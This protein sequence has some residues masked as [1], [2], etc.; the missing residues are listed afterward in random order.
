MLKILAHFWRREE[1]LFAVWTKRKLQPHLQGMKVGNVWRVI[2]KNS[3]VLVE[4]KYV[5]KQVMKSALQ[6]ASNR[7]F[8][9]KRRKHGVWCT[10]S[11][12]SRKD[13]SS[14]KLSK[15]KDQRGSRLRFQNFYYFPMH[16]H[17]PVCFL[18]TTI[19]ETFTGM[20]NFELFWVFGFFSERS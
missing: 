4:H 11:S 18:K 6:K 12:A 5:C 16:S 15:D 8:S 17:Y 1:N 7:I 9:S 2:K 3:L 10:S 20:C 19:S 14:V 13:R